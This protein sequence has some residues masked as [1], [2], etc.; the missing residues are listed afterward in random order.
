M[1]KEEIQVQI[2]ELGSWYQTIDFDGI[3]T[4]DKK[5]SGDKLWKIIKKQYLPDSMNGMRV[6]DLG[7]NAGYFSVQS[8]ILGADVIGVEGSSKFFKQAEF[9][10]KFFEERYKQSFKI[11][12]LKTD[13]SD[14]D[15]N[16]LGYFDYILAISI[17]YHIG[18][19]KFGK[20]T[21]EALFEQEIVIQKLT[22]MTNKIIVR[23]R[24]TKYNSVEYYN[25]IFEK[26]NFKFDNILAS[27][28]KRSLVLFEKII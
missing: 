24:N 12:F 11:K 4:T 27:D 5:I 8:A 9:T 13:I 16:S 7:C 3:I 1:T 23:T 6:L 15:F 14:L 20:N 26:F 10:K 18:K 21:K 28:E 25:K 22:N 2:K 19:F 17:L